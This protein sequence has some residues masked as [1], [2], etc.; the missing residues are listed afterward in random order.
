M[1]A[2]VPPKSATWLLRNLGSGPH[3]DA[4]VGDLRELFQ[5]HPSRSW[6]WR[7]VLLTIILSAL[8]E[9]RAHKILA[10]RALLVA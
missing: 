6:F 8:E 3:L 4:I 5:T 2:A 1:S 9:I 7:Q 10:L